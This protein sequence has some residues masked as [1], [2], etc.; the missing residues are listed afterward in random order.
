MSTGY[1]RSARFTLVGI[2][3]VLVG[4]TV[5]IAVA[6]TSGGTHHRPTARDVASMSTPTTAPAPLTPPTDPNGIWVVPTHQRLSSG[7]AG[8]LPNTT[9]GAVAA[10]EDLARAEFTTSTNQVTAALEQGKFEIVLGQ[11]GVGSKSVSMVVLVID[12]ID[13]VL[14]TGVV[15]ITGMLV[16]E[17]GTPLGPGGGVNANSGGWPRN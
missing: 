1:T 13:V 10:A 12:G 4:A 16:D 6:L 14:R 17:D 2:V 3:M 11:Q 5:V 8:D 15:P 7:V 9:L